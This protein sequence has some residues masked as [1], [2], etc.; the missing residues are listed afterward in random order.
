MASAM[1]RASVSVGP[2]GGLPTIMVTGRDGKISAAADV[3]AASSAG[4]AMAKP[5]KKLAMPVRLM[6]SAA[7]ARPLAALKVKR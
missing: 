4:S 6:R 7:M 3:A 2:P 5:A 1:M